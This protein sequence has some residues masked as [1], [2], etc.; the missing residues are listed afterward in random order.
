MP[1]LRSHFFSLNQCLGPYEGHVHHLVAHDWLADAGDDVRLP[2]A[3]S[4]SSASARSA[5]R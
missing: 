5:Q 3:G 1:D 4:R 2:S